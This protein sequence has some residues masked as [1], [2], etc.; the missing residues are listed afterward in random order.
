MSE[1]ETRRGRETGYDTKV[2]H[3]N[4]CMNAQIQHLS[5]ILT[6]LVSIVCS[7]PTTKG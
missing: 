4:A 2:N 7:F 3:K 1:H 5:E 6:L